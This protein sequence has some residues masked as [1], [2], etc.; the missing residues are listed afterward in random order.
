MKAASD[1][2]LRRA[3]AACRK[4][5]LWVL[6]AGIAVN[7]LMLVSPIYM[8]QIFDRVLSSGR[9]ETLIYLTVIAAFALLVLGV[10]DAMRQQVLS[11]AGGW[12]DQTLG[13]KLIDSS[14][15]GTLKGLAP[16]AQPLHDLG[17]IRGFIGGNGV[18]A[19]ID[20]PWTP[21]FIAVIWLMHPWLGMLAAAAALFLFT[22]ALINELATR[23]PLKRASEAGVEAQN[24]MVAALRNAETR[25]NEDFVEHIRDTITDDPD[26]RWIFIVD[27]LD[28]HKSAELVEF[29]ADRIGFDRDLGVKYK[30]GIL[31]SRATRTAFLSDPQHRIRFVFTPRHCSWLNQVE[32]WFSI[33]ARRVLRRGSFV[34]KQDLKAKVLAFIRYFNDVLAKPFRWTCTGR[35]LAA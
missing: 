17:Q 35:I 3:M 23:G 6:V 34:S 4:A 1:D 12:L 24:E 29:I 20:A 19:I 31:K 22:L 7:A 15:R 16:S 25:T 27:N 13:P 26:A 14:V 18:L 21:I 10:L 8:M 32:C 33:L 5:L 9:T 28:P 30:R 2:Y 11:R